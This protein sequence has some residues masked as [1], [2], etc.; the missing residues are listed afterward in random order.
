M[1]LI[2]LL[3]VLELM[4]TTSMCKNPTLLEIKKW[5][6]FD[7]EKYKTELVENYPSFNNLISNWQEGK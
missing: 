1:I 5:I 7:F 4:V 2:L 6:P 3:S